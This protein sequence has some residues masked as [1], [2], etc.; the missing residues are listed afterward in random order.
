MKSSNIKTINDLFNDF[1]SKS[2]NNTF[3]NYL[4]KEKYVNISVSTFRSNVLCLASNL[5]ELGI[6]END[7]VGIF[8]TSSPFWLIFDFAIHQLGAVSVPIFAN[9]SNKNLNFEISDS[10]IKYIF[11]DDETRIKDIKK[12]LIF[13]SHN[14]I[15]VKENYYDL[16]TLIK[17]ESH[18][19]GFE[20]YK[21]NEEDI[22]SIIYTSGNTG[23]PKGVM[24][25]HKNILSQINDISSLINLKEHE[26]I[27]SLLPLAHIFERTIMSFYL[28]HAVSVYF[29]DEITNTG[30]LLKIVRPTI[31]TA[32][33]RLLDK[34]FNKIKLNISSKPLI[35]RIIGSLAFSHAM[36]YDI[37]KD[38]F[39]FKLFDKLVY[40][41]LREIFGSR[42][43]TLVSGGAPLNKSVCNFFNNIGINIYQGYGLSEFS[44]VISSNYPGDNKI[45]SC[46]KVLPSVEIKFLNKEILARGPSVMKGYLNQKKLTKETIDQEGWLHT[47]D[48]GYLDE[49]KYLYV[50]SRKKEIYKTST[51][52]YVNT[53]FIEQELAKNSYI[54]FAVIFANNRKYVSALLFV[55]KEKF[56]AQSESKNIDEYYSRASILNNIN[57]HINK[58]NEKLNTW[59]NV[60][61]YKLIT[62]EIS[63]EN[64]ELTPS[65]KICRNKIEE[66]YV[67]EIN[68]MY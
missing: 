16:N 53:I 50:N 12:D 56:L 32:V 26:V 7:K 61:K 34:I 6:N 14:F 49:D 46:G 8:A 23:T 27:L 11:I 21:A 29:V 45:G 65:M 18:I 41:K 68:N 5:K 33:P 1:T 39:L 52:Q 31:M 47:G 13:I 4:E 30:N 36:K 67:D 20:T 60:I 15:I 51:G 55:D 57:K 17:D 59:E 40:I 48:I 37:N 25:S 62:K 9:I 22:F 64:G 19:E 28:S 58:T 54:E 2:V 24:L 44:P 3:L 63:I 66:L 43:E 38:S 42:L 35:S 10:N